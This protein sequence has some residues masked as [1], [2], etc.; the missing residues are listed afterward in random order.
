MK[1]IRGV[2]GELSDMRCF[3]GKLLTFGKIYKN[4]L[5]TIEISLKI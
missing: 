5:F 3:S 1:N 4:K 2:P